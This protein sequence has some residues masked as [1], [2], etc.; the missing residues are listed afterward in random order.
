MRRYIQRP[1]ARQCGGSSGSTQSAQQPIVRARMDSFSCSSAAESDVEETSSHATVPERRRWKDIYA[2]R[3]VVER[4]WRNNRYTQRI[5]STSGHPS[6]RAMTLYMDDSHLV[7]GSSDNSIRL[8][9][10]ETGECLRTFTG[11]TDTV[12][13][14]Q[15][16]GSIV[17]SGSM[18]RT[19][20]IWNRNSGECLRTLNCHSEGVT[21]LHFSDGTLSSG[22]YDRTIR[23]MHC[24]SNTCVTLLG[25]SKTV[26]QV[27]LYGKDHVISCSDDKTVRF[28]EWRTKT[29]LRSFNDHMSEIRCFQTT[30]F[31]ADVIRCLLE[32]GMM[33]G[34]NLLAYF[35]RLPIELVEKCEL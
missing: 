30:P 15:F 18:D 5:L 16:D 7:S 25:H 12:R 29:C 22:S 26:N 13:C 17:I 32:P 28:W 2:E 34:N 14:V 31:Q 11:H 4:N 21:T 1:A 10:L 6:D 35:G 3:L 20:R 23:V 33:N 9:D 27:R 24:A 8:W 19:L